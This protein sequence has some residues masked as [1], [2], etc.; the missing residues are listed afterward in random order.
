M[1]TLPH[2][3]WVEVLWF[4]V[5]GLVLPLGHAGHSVG[6]HVQLPGELEVVVELHR[7]VSLKVVVKPF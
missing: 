4:T 1:Q 6:L 2:N 5:H 7:R 3:V